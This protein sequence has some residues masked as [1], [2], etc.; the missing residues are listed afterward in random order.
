MFKP[1]VFS[2][3]THRISLSE[4]QKETIETL[5]WLTPAGAVI[6]QITEKRNSDRPSGLLKY[7]KRASEHT[8]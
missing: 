8:S 6:A 4:D 3:P 7:T 1:P 5:T 2:P